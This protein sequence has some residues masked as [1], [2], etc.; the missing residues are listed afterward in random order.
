[1]ASAPAI[2]GFVG[3]N[4]QSALD[5]TREMYH[6]YLKKHQRISIPSLDYRGVPVGL[7]ALRVLETNIMPVINTGIA[8]REPGIGQIGAG[9]CRAPQAVFREGVSHVFQQVH[10]SSPSQYHQFAVRALRALKK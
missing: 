4:A 5:T 6:I 8:H 9:I 3:G 2:T 7:D 1:M 10:A